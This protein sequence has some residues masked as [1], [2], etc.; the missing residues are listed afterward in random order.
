MSKYKDKNGTTRVGDFLRSINFKD[1]ASV[2]GNVASGNFTQVIKTLTNSKELTQEQI[3][4]SLKELEYD[5]REMQ[6]ITK[7]WESDN[8]TES[9]L[10]KNIRPLTLA[11]LTSTLFI[12][13]ILDSSLKGFSVGSEW[14]S[15]LKGL[16]ML[17]YGGYFGVRSVEK[18]FK[19]KNDT[20]S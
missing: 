15:L 11:F 8:K 6:E 19:I 18:V 3:D 16:M 13:I 4:K 14:V 10:T 12:Y 20:K 9:Y 1:V 5:M 2:V 7:R 17:A